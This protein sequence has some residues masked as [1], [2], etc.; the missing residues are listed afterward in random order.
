[1]GKH[2]GAQGH[3]GY[4]QGAGEVHGN[5]RKLGGGQR[6]SGVCGDVCFPPSR[7]PPIAHHASA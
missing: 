6:V 5:L 7:C 2:S 1:M 3:V 4:G